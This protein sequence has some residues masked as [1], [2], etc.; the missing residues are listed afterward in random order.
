VLGRPL[1]VIGNPQSA[2]ARGAAFCALAACEGSS[3]DSLAGT[4]SVARWIR[5]RRGPEPYEA[6]YRRFLQLHQALAQVAG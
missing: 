1:G 6:R 4:V 5:P 3:L 2:G